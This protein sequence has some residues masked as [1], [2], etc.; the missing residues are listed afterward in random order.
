MKERFLSYYIEKFNANLKINGLNFIEIIDSNL[1]AGQIRFED[2]GIVYQLYWDKKRNN[3]KISIK[4][5]DMI[6]WKIVDL[7]DDCKD[8]V[9]SFI[10][11]YITEKNGQFK[12]KSKVIK[13]SIKKEDVVKDIGSKKRV[14][15]PKGAVD[16]TKRKPKKKA[17]NQK[18]AAIRK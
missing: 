17:Y 3:F 16:T 1:K 15:R 7:V 4:D 8:D 10:D 2:K 5:P 11:F 9:E 13:D 18:K 6:D 12:N 14:G